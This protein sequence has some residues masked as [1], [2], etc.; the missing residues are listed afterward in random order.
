MGRISDLPFL[1]TFGAFAFLCPLPFLIY[2]IDRRGACW[3]GVGGQ[4]T[5]ATIGKEPPTWAMSKVSRSEVFS[6]NPILFG[7][8]G[9]SWSALTCAGRKW[10]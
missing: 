10:W 5:T 9:A 3:V 8:L 1:S 4:V 2:Y 6:S 7:I